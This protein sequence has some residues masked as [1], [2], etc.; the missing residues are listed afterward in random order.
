VKGE[1]PRQIIHL[2]EHRIR[3]FFRR[4]VAQEDDVL[5]LTQDVVCAILSGYE[6]FRGA[7][8]VSTWVYGICKNQLYS[9]YHRSNRSKQLVSRLSRLPAVEDDSLIG[10]LELSFDRLR[11]DQRKL[12]NDFYRYRM[13]IKE[14]AAESGRPEGTIKYL[15]HELRKDLASVMG[16]D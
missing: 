6:R 13:T 15:L 4:H 14:I 3:R 7:S 8:A 5:D 11:P 12:Y 2:Y 16:A 1:S 9:F 10:L